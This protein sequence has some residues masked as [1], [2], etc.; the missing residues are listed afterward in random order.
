MELLILFCC[1]VSSL[2]AEDANEVEK[3]TQD[4]SQEVT[5]KDFARAMVPIFLSTL[6]LI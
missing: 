4:T 1:Y 6:K 3:E 2:W 5:S